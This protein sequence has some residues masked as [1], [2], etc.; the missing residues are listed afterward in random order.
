MLPSS[1]SDS[2]HEV[3]FVARIDVL[4]ERVDTLASTIATTASAMAKRDGEIAALRKELDARDER[5]AAFVTQSREAADGADLRELKEAVAALT[6]EGSKRG[7]SKQIDDLTAKLGL[8]GQ[9]LDTLSTTVSTTAAGLAGREGE[10]ATIRKRLDSSLPG[11]GSAAPAADPELRNQLAGLSSAT[12]NMATRLDEQGAEV[13]ALKAR[14]ASRETDSPPA[15]DELRAMLAML[16]TR[17]E[18]LDGLRGGVTEEVLDDRLTETTD[19]LAHISARVDDLASSLEAATARVADKE[20]ELAAL[21]RHFLESNARVESVVDDLR[22]AL[23]AFPETDPGALAALTA[24]LETNSAGVA[25]V[26]SRVDRLEGAH[27]ADLG[28]ELGAR[29]DL[30]DKR[31]ETVA[32][33]IK[34]A[35]TLWPVALRSL[36]ARLDDLVS[37]RRGADASQ[38]HEPAEDEDAH[39]GDD[40]EDLLAQLRDSLQAMENVAAEMER[41]SDGWAGDDAPDGPPNMQQAVGGGAQVVPLRTGDP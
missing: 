31:I 27:V 28:A 13:D 17:M 32:V 37:P 16:R 34:R 41:T 18:S 19:A 23:G 26:A 35:K 4:G 33:E 1:K 21:H 8:L 30:M 11:S 12:T 10:L 36:E 3:R 5:L 20:H 22:E 9:R 6:S 40:S 2:K 25:S 39:G 29:I 15:S 7:G 38:A 24:Q 14:L